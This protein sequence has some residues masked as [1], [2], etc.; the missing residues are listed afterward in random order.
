[1]SEEEKEDLKEATDWLSALDVNSEWEASNKETIL[2]TV[3]K[4][5]KVIDLMADKL[6]RHGF[7]VVEPVK[8]YDVESELY[9]KS[10]TKEEI[11]EYFYK[12][13]EEENGQ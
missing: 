8:K 12:K 10:K 6:F 13:A 2:S 9:I 1:M 5:Q 7:F 4:L 11:K 3:D